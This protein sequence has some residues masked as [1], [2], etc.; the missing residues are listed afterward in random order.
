MRTSRTG[1]LAAIPGGILWILGTAAAVLGELDYRGITDNPIPDAVAFGIV[2]LG[3]ILLLV[4]LINIRRIQA[5]RGGPS[6]GPGYYIALAGLAV[7]A[8]SV[9]P[10]IFLGPML[11][12]IGATIYGGATLASRS[13][14]SLGTW[15]HVLSIPL[16]IMTGFA[17]AAV[18][19][20]G[21]L[22]IVVFSALISGG[23]MSLG[24][25]VAA[26]PV[27]STVREQTA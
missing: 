27:A 17:S 19:Y 8:I 24:Y 3:S 7:T 25:D 4:G 6:G 2:S 26:S 20:D 18:G 9:W 5:E 12:G 13:T 21:G 1:A 23:F 14:R 16:G 22:G 10:F 11:V 15:M